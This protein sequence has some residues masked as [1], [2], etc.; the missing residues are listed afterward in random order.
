MISV[1]DQNPFDVAPDDER[2]DD[3]VQ[4]PT[5]QRPAFENTASDEAPSAA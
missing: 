3:A 5:P 4:Q 2:R 1:N